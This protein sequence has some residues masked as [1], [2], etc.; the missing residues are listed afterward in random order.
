VKRRQV[1]YLS[2]PISAVPARSWPQH[3]EKVDE[4][5]AKIARAGFSV[6]VP[7]LLPGLD[8]NECLAADRELVL[9]SDVLYLFPSR[10]TAASAG[11]RREAG[12]ARRAGLRVVKSMEQLKGAA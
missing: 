10:W 11:M 4:T 6:I 1:C 3:K 8:W 7:S 2:F 12:W 5:A 9:R